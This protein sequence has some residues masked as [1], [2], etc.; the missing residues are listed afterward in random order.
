MRYRLVNDFV[1]RL[2]CAAAPVLC[3]MATAA[4]PLP[5]LRADASQLSVSGLSSGG[6]MAVQFH[7]AFSAS[8]IGAGIVAGGPFYCAQNQASIAVN[9]C[10]LPDADHPLPPIAALV[11]FTRSAAQAGAID[12]TANL[13]GARVWL[14][15][16]RKD[17]TVRQPV[18]DALQRYCLNFVPAVQVAYVNT[19]DAGHAFPTVN[20]G[21]ECAYTGAP[22]IDRCG[23]DGA[24]LLLQQIH[25]SLASPGA[26]IDANLREFDQREFFDHADA[27][28]HSM[29]HAGYVY[30]PAACRVGGCRIHVAFHGCVQNAGSVGERFVRHAGYNNW[31]ENNRFIILYP[32]TIARYGP[33]FRF[34]RVSYVLN[35]KGCWDWWGYDS[36]GYYRKD[37]PQMQAVMR[38]VRRLAAQ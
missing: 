2:L 18:M 16:G 38:M 5:A 29:R 9:N 3:G 13:A 7:V 12:A 28:S 35:P 11:A 23:I 24:G 22:F 6:Y 10:M 33:G 31:A 14:F 26:A 27:Y 1:R 30:I 8:V 37:G 19:F 15:S 21:A 36:A 20:Y 25:G 34:W 17:L 4:E 32:Q